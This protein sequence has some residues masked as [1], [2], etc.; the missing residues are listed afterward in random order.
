MFF[1][2]L[3]ENGKDA[4]IWTDHEAAEEP[5]TIW[6]AAFDAGNFALLAMVNDPVAGPQAP[7]M[8]AA[9]HD[10]PD[11]CGLSFVWCCWLHGIKAGEAQAFGAAAHA[12]EESQIYADG[13]FTFV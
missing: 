11:A 10:K 2:V 8:A 1:C 4:E 5:Q 3:I 9:P 7:L 13:G 6:R 12:I